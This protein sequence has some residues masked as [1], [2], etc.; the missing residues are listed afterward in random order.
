MRSCLLFFLALGI[1][2][3]FCFFIPE[4]KGGRSQW[5]K[6]GAKPPS[7]PK[8]GVGEKE[9]SASCGKNVDQV[10]GTVGRTIDQ[11]RSQRSVRSLLEMPSLM[12]HLVGTHSNH[13]K[14]RKSADTVHVVSAKLLSVSAELAPRIMVGSAALLS[15][16]DS[17]VI[18]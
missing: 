8:H 2:C 7:Q 13:G 5:N 14:H 16:C 9:T 4:Q 17:K 15:Q 18:P 11:L 12:L 1:F 3:F 6:G 10:S